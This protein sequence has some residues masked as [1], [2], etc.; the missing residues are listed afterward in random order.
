M[1]VQVSAL[2]DFEAL[3]EPLLLRRNVSRAAQQMA[4][5]ADNFVAVVLGNALVVEDPWSVRHYS[6]V[7]PSRAWP[8]RSYVRTL[9]NTS[10]LPMSFAVAFGHCTVLLWADRTAHGLARHRRGQRGACNAARL[11]GGRSKAAAG[12]R[13]CGRHVSIAAAVHATHSLITLMRAAALPSC[14]KVASHCDRRAMRNI[15][16]N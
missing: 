1:I 5:R 7:P 14:M 12:T 15:H 6:A 16:G 3:A 13:W 11:C 4:E 2:H 9:H 8:R 10:A